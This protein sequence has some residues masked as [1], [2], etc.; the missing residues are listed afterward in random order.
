MNRSLLTLALLLPASAMAWEP[1]GSVWFLDDMPIDYQISDYEEDSL[2]PGETFEVIQTAFG[3]W[4]AATCA[5]TEVNYTGPTPENTPFIL[6]DGITR[7]SWDDPGDNHG[8]GT[9]A[10]ASW[11]P[12]FTETRLIQGVRYAHTTG[13]DIVFND[14]VQWGNEEEVTSPTCSG[15]HS[16][17]AVGVHEIGHWWGLGHTC[18]AIDS[19]SDTLDLEATMYYALDTCVNEQAFPNENDLEGLTTLYGPSTRIQCSHEIS[20]GEADTVAFGVAPMEIRCRVTERG[21]ETFSV[22]EA[23]WYF[24]DG[25]EEQTGLDAVHT[26]EEPGNYSITATV[27]GTSDACGPWDTTVSRNSYVRV[28]GPPDVAMDV[29]HIDGRRYN[30]LNET[31]LSSTACIYRVQWDIFDPDGGLEASLPTWEP[32]YEFLQNGEYRLVLN[33]GGPAGTSAHELN[34]IV[35]NRRGEGYSTCSSLGAGMLSPLVLLLPL[36]FRRRRD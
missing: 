13:G 34:V 26:Y 20:P 19:C 15:L 12:D 2:D 16:V 9:L 36:V 22:T 27:S 11:N 31:D 18:E 6:N 10:V 14:G 32:E 30:L 1:T 17:V 35:R 7:I 29:E 3:R 23:S 4:D 25:T 5:Q 24:G 28:C 8:A 21:D 33:V